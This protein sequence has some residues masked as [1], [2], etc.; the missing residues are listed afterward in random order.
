[1]N[2]ELAK[3]MQ[4]LSALNPTVQN[5]L[6]NGFT[7]AVTQAVQAAQAAAQT[8]NLNQSGVAT[9]AAGK[10]V[11]EAGQAPGVPVSNNTMPASGVITTGK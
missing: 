1:M 11:G 3:S 6:I 4:N 9:N 2:P 8:Q 10:I 5:T 7:Q